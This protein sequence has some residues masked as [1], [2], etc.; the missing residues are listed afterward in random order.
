[1]LYFMKEKKLCTGC[2]ACYNICP[3]KCIA[4]EKDKEG[5]L[6]PTASDKC[7]HCGK[8]EIVCPAVFVKTEDSNNNITPVA[9]CALTKDSKVWRQSAS[10]GA[11][12][13]ICKA[14]DVG[15]SV[16]CGAAWNGLN[17]EHRCIQ[18]IDNI[19]P[20]RKSKYIASDTKDVFQKIKNYL[21]AGKKAVFCGTPC[22]VAGLKHFL[23]KG[24]ENLLLIDLICH[25][26]GSPKVFQACINNISNQFGWDVCS[27]EFRAKRTAH[28]TDY[29]Q[30][31]KIKGGKS[32]YIEN[33]PY[34]QLFLS[35]QCLRPSCGKNCRFRSA[36]RQ[37]DIT[38]AD[39]KGLTNVFPD[40]NGSRKNYSSIIFNTQKGKSVIPQL[41]KSMKMRECD[42]ED[43]KKYNP[44][45]Y[46]HTWSSERRDV[47]FQEFVVSPEQTIKKW[48]KPAQISKENLLRLVWRY[49]PTRLRK[50]ILELRMSI[51]KKR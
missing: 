42:I 20:L 38:I 3:T 51:G 30:K 47:F 37:G 49:T 24:Q 9:Y 15:D 14:W 39:F 18:G 22:Q 35:Q 29:L 1:M 8:C 25:G 31:V 34:M 26:A 32:I 12:T 10:G 45:F 23:G 5:F 40:L 33:D 48:C 4:M 27:Y 41:S 17:I 19:G 6:Y 43:I 46:R 28:Q 7:V 2:G 36:Q 11:F 50:N 21:S 13:E 16:F 44:L